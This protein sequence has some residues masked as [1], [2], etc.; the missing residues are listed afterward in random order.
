MFIG[1]FDLTDSRSRGVSSSQADCGSS[2]SRH[3]SIDD[4]MREQQEMF[5]EELRQQQTTFL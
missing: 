3:S 5:H 4:T 1:V 2:R